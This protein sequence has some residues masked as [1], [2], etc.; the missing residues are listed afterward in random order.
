MVLIAYYIDLKRFLYSSKYDFFE[1]CNKLYFSF[2]ANNTC[3]LIS[4]IFSN[5]LNSQIL[6]NHA[7]F[8][9]STSI[10]SQQFRVGYINKH[11]FLTQLQIIK[12]TEINFFI[13]LTNFY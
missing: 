10:S 8:L 1:Y 2:L 13:Q 9:I 3:K 5:D 7:F 11:G 12:V 6:F 4:F